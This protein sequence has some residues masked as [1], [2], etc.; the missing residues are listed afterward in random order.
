MEIHH[1]SNSHGKKN[2]KS[3]IWEFLMLFLAVF[4]GFLAEYQLEHKIER[5]R[6]KEYILSMIEDATTDIVNI[7]TAIAL[8]TKRIYNL[9]SLANKSFN[10]GLPGI[11]DPSLYKL[12]QSCLRHP[13]FVSPTE[14]TMTQL[15]NS[16]GMRLLQNKTAV[17]SIL[18]YDDF[19]KKLTNQQEWYEN[20]LRELIEPGV[21]IFN[22]KYNPEIDLDKLK[23]LR[24]SSYD[25]A[26]LNITEKSLLIEL[27]NRAIMYR[28]VVIFYIRLLHEGELHA[29]NLK[30]TLQ[31]KY[32]IKNE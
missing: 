4:C 7:H 12:F 3:Y 16:G 32:Q 5:D 22:F 10:Y 17:D 25:S 29:A 27:G 26:K 1:H 30:Q 14:R 19:A 6:E 18:Q 24:S 9:D 11:D 23:P 21:K 20:M 28:N 15:M 31:N 13:D 8:N 2:W